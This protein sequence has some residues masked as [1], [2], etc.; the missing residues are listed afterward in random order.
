MQRR[1]FLKFGLAS[2]AS[3]LA[4]NPAFSA[5]QPQ[6]YEYLM[7]DLEQR[8][9]FRVIRID[10]HSTGLLEAEFDN[11]DNPFILYSKDTQQWYSMP[12]FS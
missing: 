11:G 9:G 3:L 7:L 5:Q 1:N 12:Q 4:P 6:D 10:Q 8:L 2:G